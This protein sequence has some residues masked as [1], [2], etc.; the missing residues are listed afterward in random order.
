MHA[1]IWK[2]INPERHCITKYGASTKF[3]GRSDLYGGLIW[4][5]AHTVGYLAM[6]R[7]P[8]SWSIPIAPTILPWLLPYM[9]IL[10]GWY[11]ELLLE[12]DGEQCTEDQCTAHTFPSEL[13]PWGSSPFLLHPH[14]FVSLLL[15]WLL[16]PLFAVLKRC[17][18]DFISRLYRWSACRLKRAWA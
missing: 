6:C 17:S 12:I 10:L 15:E 16:L 9:V 7:E 11:R 13:S 4:L 3:G 2:P 1:S 18:K 5:S 14:C 8:L